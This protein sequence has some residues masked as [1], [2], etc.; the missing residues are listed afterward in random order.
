MSTLSL[1]DFAEIE[2]ENSLPWE[3]FSAFNKKYTRATEAIMMHIK[4]AHERFFEKVRNSTV[5]WQ[6]YK[7][8][9]KYTH[10]A[11]YD[12]SLEVWRRSIG[13]AWLASGVDKGPKSELWGICENVWNQLDIRYCP[14]YEVVRLLVEHTAP[15]W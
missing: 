15:H 1:F 11:L 12:Q 3:A 13:K 4:S 8:F 6:K 2:A 14:K 9:I 10:A 5:K 7:F